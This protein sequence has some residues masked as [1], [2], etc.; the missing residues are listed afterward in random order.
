MTVVFTNVMKCRAASRN[1]F[2]RQLTQM[3]DHTIACKQQRITYQ[4]SQNEE[5]EVYAGSPLTKLRIHASSLFTSYVYVHMHFHKR[6][7][8]YTLEN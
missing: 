2:T 1:Q 4:S 8:V 6:K 7:S 5:R 3:K